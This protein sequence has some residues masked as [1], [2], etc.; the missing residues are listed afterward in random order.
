MKRMIAFLLAALPTLM[1]G[2]TVQDVIRTDSTGNPPAY[3]QITQEED[4]PAAGRS[5]KRLKS[6]FRKLI[7]NVHHKAASQGTVGRSVKVKDTEEST[8]TANAPSLSSQQS[9][10]TNTVESS[11]SAVNTQRVRISSIGM[12][13]ANL[14]KG[15]KKPASLKEETDKSTGEH[16]P[17]DND[18]LLLQW[19]AMCNRMPQQMAGMAARM[20]NMTPTIT[21]FPEIEVVIDNEILLNQMTSIQKRIRN[22]LAINLHNSDITLSLRLAKADEVKKILSNRELLEEMRIQHPALEKLLGGLELELA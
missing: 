14:S 17:F 8:A 15:Q 18:M 6:L 11:H 22:T 13:F 1:V 20:K 10:P 21:S 3:T 16:Q 2:C 5:P 4:T 19:T 9:A 12:T 7:S